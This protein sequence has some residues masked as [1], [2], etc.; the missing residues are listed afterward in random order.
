MHPQTIEEKSYWIKHVDA[1]RRG[2][3]AS[4][5][6]YCSKF[7]VCYHRFLYWCQKIIK[8]L[9]NKGGLQRDA[10][11]MPIKVVPQELPVTSPA[12]L[13]CTLEFK[14]GHKLNIHNE[15]VLEKLINLLGK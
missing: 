13:L 14:Q 4:K 12:S 15:S 3:F 1:Y 8:E 9:A 11:F 6:A 7:G 5:A 10:L 2:N